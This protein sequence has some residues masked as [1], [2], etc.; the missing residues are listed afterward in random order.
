MIRFTQ[1]IQTQQTVYVVCNSQGQALY[2]TTSIT[3]AI[4]LIQK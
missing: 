3:Q 4:K 1:D 2:L